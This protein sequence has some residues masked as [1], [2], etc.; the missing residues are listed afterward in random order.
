MLLRLLTP[1]VFVLVVRSVL[2]MVL[3]NYVQEL[4][5]PALKEI[6][7]NGT[8]VSTLSLYCLSVS[9]W[10]LNHALIINDALTKA[11]FLARAQLTLVLG[12]EPGGRYTTSL[13]AA[14]H[15]ANES[16]E[17]DLQAQFGEKV[18][19]ALV[20]QPGTWVAS[21]KG[22]RRRDGVVNTTQ[23]QAK[24]K[25]G[26]GDG[27]GAGARV[28][29]GAEEYPKDAE[30]DSDENSEAGLVSRS[31]RPSSVT[32]LRTVL[33][34]GWT[35]VRAV[36]E[37]ARLVIVVPLKFVLFVDTGPSTTS[38]R[39]CGLGVRPDEFMVHVSGICAERVDTWIAGQALYAFFTSLWS[40]QGM[41]AVPA[42]QA[43]FMEA[44]SVIQ[45]SLFNTSSF[46]VDALLTIHL[47]ALYLVLPTYFA[48][49]YGTWAA[50]P[51]V[52]SIVLS[53]APLVLTRALRNPFRHYQTRHVD[54]LKEMALE[55]TPIMGFITT[56]HRNRII[57][58]RASTCGLSE[59]FFTAGGTTS[60]TFV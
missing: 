46:M 2:L 33:G 45:S 9:A 38:P 6:M 41:A 25:A 12:S 40:C 57:C 22:K 54:A 1:F 34:V 30:G 37:V 20:L 47:T 24:T 16:M 7:L 28:G 13:S 29:A 26:D 60:E 18:S 55:F 4:D 35:L 17:Q 14:R 51:V 52:I 42:A 36:A 15:A 19:W 39:A 58:A 56:S 10:S 27:A 43:T 48:A 21:G 50:V 49:K 5:L 32:A 44:A 53:I 23:V 59:C 11:L 31:Q 8:L 3:V